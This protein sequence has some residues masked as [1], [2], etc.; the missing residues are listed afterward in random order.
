[1]YCDAHSHLC[2]AELFPYA[3]ELIAQSQ[4]VIVATACWEDW[5]R[6]MLLVQQNNQKL[7]AA[8]GIHPWFANQWN[9]EVGEQLLQLITQHRMAAIGEIGLDFLRLEVSRNQQLQVFEEQLQMATEANLPVIVH[10]VK[11]WQDMRRLI[12]KYCLSRQGWL[13]HGFNGSFEM[14]NEVLALNGT[15]SFGRSLLRSPKLQH[16]LSQLPRDKIVLESDAD[17]QV[18]IWQHGQDIYFDFLQQLYEC[19]AQLWQCS[20]ETVSE[21]MENNLKNLFNRSSSC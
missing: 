14:A 17:Q 11:A 2:C 21:Q 3:Q 1:M 15:L 16:L 9:H 10:Q 4:Q 5:Q 8:Y 20:V 6:L 12:K 7:V 18:L 19:V 13:Y